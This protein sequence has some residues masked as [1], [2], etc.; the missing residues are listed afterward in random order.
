MTSAPKPSEA[1]TELA[2]KVILWQDH[3]H[4]NGYRPKLTMLKFPDGRLA[5][6]INVHGSCQVFPYTKAES[7]HE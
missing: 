5:I 4:P 2:E 6:E 7:G 1:V 3:T